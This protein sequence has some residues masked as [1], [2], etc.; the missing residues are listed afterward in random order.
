MLAS[1]RTT[2][3]MRVHIVDGERNFLTSTM[4][5]G[6]RRRAVIGHFWPVANR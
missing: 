3:R 6:S 5:E 4:L 2:L 1:E